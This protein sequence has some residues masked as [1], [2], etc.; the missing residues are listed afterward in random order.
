MLHPTV[1]GNSPSHSCPRRRSPP[2][3]LLL[4]ACCSEA[5]PRLG[6]LLQI[7]RPVMS[8]SYCSLCPHRNSQDGG[9]PHHHT[10]H[11]GS[12]QA[13]C[14]HCS[15]RKRHPLHRQGRSK[16]GKGR[17]H[18]GETTVFSVGR[19]LN[20]LCQTWSICSDGPSIAES[21]LSS[22]IPFP[23]PTCPTPGTL[24]LFPFRCPSSSSVARSPEDP[25]A[26]CTWKCLWYVAGHDAPVASLLLLREGDSSLACPADSVLGRGPNPRPFKAC[27]PSYMRAGLLLPNR[28]SDPSFSNLIR[29]GR[30]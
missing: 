8:F 10:V 29:K 2:E 4:R 19:Y 17:M 21:L 25:G 7:T 22:P 1:K 11:L 15:K 9:P 3:L 24:L 26:S 12:T 6:R 30:R 16:D 27:Y 23:F 5:A 20:E 18:P 14:I 13:P 28:A